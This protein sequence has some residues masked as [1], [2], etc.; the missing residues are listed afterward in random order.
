M[1]AGGFYLLLIGILSTLF[2]FR[3]W[4][5]LVLVV[6]LRQHQRLGLSLCA[7]VRMLVQ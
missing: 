6:A 3:K 5:V 7:V 4:L 2:G 1:V